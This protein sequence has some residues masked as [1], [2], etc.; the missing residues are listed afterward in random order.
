MSVSQ[1]KQWIKCENKA[2]AMFVT[3]EYEQEQTEA[4]KA[5]SYAHSI[6]EGTQD[7][8]RERNPDIIAQ[9]GKNKGE[10]K[11]PYRLIDNAMTRA[12]SDPYFKA[13]LQGEKETIWIAEIYG[14]DWKCRIDVINH[15]LNFIADLKTTRNFDGEWINIDGKNVKVPFYEA[16]NYW[17]QFAIYREIVRKN[18]GISYDLF[19]PVI[20]KEDPPNY[21]VLQFEDE[22]RL[23]EELEIVEEKLKRIIHV[24]SGAL[25]PLSCDDCDYCRMT[26][27]LTSIS[28]ARSWR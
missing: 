14:I 11:E 3:A 15:E 19:C 9:S 8:F 22:Y 6:S 17:L 27:K 21:N 23:N 20:T 5:G 13:V 26:K 4:M 7:K 18:T 28:I 24:K 10:L 12:I 16:Y 25:I 2:L 1:F